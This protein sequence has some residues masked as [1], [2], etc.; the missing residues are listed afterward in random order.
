[1]TGGGKGRGPFALKNW[2]GR[3]RYHRKTRKYPPVL[4]VFGICNRCGLSFVPDWNEKLSMFSARCRP[5]REK[6]LLE[7]IFTPNPNSR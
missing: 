4:P 5:C 1:M 6:T 2:R 7:F 3:G